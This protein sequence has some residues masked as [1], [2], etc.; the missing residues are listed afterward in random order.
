MLHMG[1]YSLLILSSLVVL[2]TADGDDDN[3]NYNVTNRPFPKGFKFGVAT[4][5][6]QIEGA[7]NIDG[8]GPQMWDDFFHETPSRAFDG[9]NG[10]VAVDSYHLY[11]ED[12]RC[13]KEVG[14]DYYRLSLSWARIL[15]NGTTDNINQLGVDYY[16]RVFE[17]LEAKGIKTMVTIYHWDLPSALLARGGWLNPDI[18]DWFADYAELCYKLFGKYA[19]SW[20]TINEPK[21]ICHGGYGIGAYAPGIVSNGIKDYVCAKYVLLAHAKAWRIYDERYRKVNGAKNTLVI[22]SDWYEPVTDSEEDAIASD[23]KLQFVHGMYGNPVVNG[24][25]PD[26]M[27]ENVA[28]L[29]RKQGFNESRLPAFTEEEQKLLKGTYDFFALNHYTTYMVKARTN[30]VLTVSWDEDSKVDIYQKGRDIWKPAA[31]DW[32][33]IV[34]WGFGKLLRWMRKTYGNVEIVITENGV[35]DQTGILKDQ[36]RIDFLRNYMSHM[37]DAIHEADV[38]VT[39]YTLWTIMDNFEWTLGYIGKSGLYYVNR[40]DPTLPRIPKDSAKYYSKI[41][42]TK[43][44]IDECLNE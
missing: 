16:T 40:T 38:N 13:M 19:D 30:E 1:L 15:P 43:C 44:L 39:A 14:V 10:D 22:D 17:A 2:G 31:I 41:I 42:K 21:Q 24:N 35:S 5:S 37:L 25:W 9:S 18:V 34:P 33:R 3:K 36:T 23:T 4:A 29:S 27:I 28:D 32:F 12:I 6:Y 7:W 20:I 26:V 11:N 8:K